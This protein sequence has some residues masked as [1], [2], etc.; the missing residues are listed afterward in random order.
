[1][2]TKNELIKKKKPKKYHSPTL[3]T[4]Q[5]VEDVISEKK[6]FRS[7]NQLFRD[8]PKQVNNQTLNIILIYLK[9]HQKII[10]DDDGS[11]ISNQ[12]TAL[13][14]LYEKFGKSKKL[15]EEK[16]NN[17]IKSDI[18]V[19]LGKKKQSFEELIMS[20]ELDEDLIQNNLHVL[21]NKGC[22]RSQDMG[23]VKKYLLTNNGLENFELSQ[24]INHHL[25]KLK[26]HIE[27]E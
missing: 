15:T 11:I 26:L 25:D 24:K 21:I 9:K 8:L 10:I 22:V 18:I 17:I 7:K 4:I 12:Q 19:S 27:G 16:I 23:D 13:S 1:M 2:S 14:T 20:C 5:M 6:R 3:E